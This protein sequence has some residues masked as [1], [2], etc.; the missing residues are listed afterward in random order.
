M[1]QPHFVFG[2]GSLVK[3]AGLR[4]FLRRNANRPV[5][6]CICQ[7]QG[8]RRCWNVAMDNT[9][10]LHSYKY[11]LD[12]GTGYRPEVYVTFLNIRSAVGYEITGILF[13]VTEEELQMLDAR[14]RNYTRKEVSSA[15]SLP[16]AGKV[17]VY[18]GTKAARERYAY[19]LGE[20]RACVQADYFHYVHD[21]FLQL[22]KPHVQAYL[23]STDPPEVPIRKLKRIDL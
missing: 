3:E 15:I 16:S 18:E 23:D 17:W 2:F 9:Q 6:S 4:K 14:E 10:N 1:S 13:Q 5:E 12:L 8:Y 19:G 21:C 20:S 7:L 22:G 11:Y